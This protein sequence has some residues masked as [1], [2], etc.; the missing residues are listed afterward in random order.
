[1][2]ATG[3][4]EGHLALSEDFVMGEAF[5]FI[6]SL[7]IEVNTD[8]PLGFGVVPTSEWQN[9]PT[10]FFNFSP[11]NTKWANFC[12]IISDGRTVRCDETK[13]RASGANMALDGKEGATREAVR[14]AAYGYEQ[15]TQNQL[16]KPRDTTHV[17]VQV[18]PIAGTLT[19]EGNGNTVSLPM[20]YSTGTRLMLALHMP[21]KLHA[22]VDRKIYGGQKGRKDPIH[23]DIATI[24]ELELRD[25][26]RQEEDEKK[27]MAQQLDLGTATSSVASGDG[28]NN[29]HNWSPGLRRELCFVAKSSARTS[30]MA[31]RRYAAEARRASRIAKEG[32]AAHLILAD[33]AKAL[34][35]IAEEDIARLEGK[36]LMKA[37]E[38]TRQELLDHTN[39][40]GTERTKS[41]QLK[42]EAEKQLLR[43]HTY[44]ARAFLQHRWSMPCVSVELVR[45]LDHAVSMPYSQCVGTERD[46]AGGFHHSLRSSSRTSEFNDEDQH[47]S[48][49]FNRLNETWA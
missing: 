1:M 22:D 32:A 43:A 20:S 3:I 17:R 21:G 23:P 49:K 6:V 34:M 45:A 18:N 7:V 25:I 26:E 36:K 27:M 35:E 29:K 5:P 31:C 48:L 12:A 44:D 46:R 37:A 42:E 8:T 41:T 9:Q 38:R 4:E 15:G 33:K 39:V 19:V 11:P 47:H 24:N 28:Q 40:E 30:R 2:Q 14:G 13:I 10:S 16:L